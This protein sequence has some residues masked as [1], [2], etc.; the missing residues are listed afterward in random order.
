MAIALPVTPLGSPR[1]DRHS[2]TYISSQSRRRPARAFSVLFLFLL[3]WVI[4][5]WN[6]GITAPS[7]RISLQQA[8]S[9]FRGTAVRRNYIDHNIPTWLASYI[10]VAAWPAEMESLSLAKH[11][12]PK[13][14]KEARV[15]YTERLAR[16]SKTL[17]Q[18]QAEYQRRYKRSP[19]KGFATW[20]ES[21]SSRS[22]PG[23][24][25]WK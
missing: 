18:A 7:A 11:P 13:L 25:G 4:A 17:S 2:T 8:V 21:A 12:I 20:F 9:R 6:L 3:C 14:I 5:V 16:Q 10:P 19:P 24:T 23:R 15:K 22:G 1:P